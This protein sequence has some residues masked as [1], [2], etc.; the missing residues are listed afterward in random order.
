MSEV[1]LEEQ[2]AT[3]IAEACEEAVA[4]GVLGDA[5]CAARV[6]AVVR[7]QIAHD[8]EVDADSANWSVGVRNGLFEA[9]AI[10]RGPHS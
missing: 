4:C 7:E 3:A 6:I 2:V 1:S 5:E 10:A 9:A 8:I